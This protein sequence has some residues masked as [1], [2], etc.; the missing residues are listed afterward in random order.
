MVKLTF[1]GGVDEIGGNKILL[2]YG[3]TR[4]FLDF[5]VSFKKFKRFFDFPTVGPDNVDILIDIGDL[6]LIPNIYNQSCSKMLEKILELNLNLNLSKA[7]T[8]EI[9]KIEKE[10]VEKNNL[11]PFIDAVVITHAHAD[12]MG[13]IATLNNRVKILMGE[14]TKEICKILW[15]ISRIYRYKWKT[16]INEL[17][18]ETFKTG[19]IKEVGIDKIRIEPIAV[20][21]SVPAAYG[22]IIHLPNG[23]KIA[24]TGDFRYGGSENKFTEKFVRRLEEEKIDV[25]ICEA[26]HIDIGHWV[27]E[28][29]VNND[30]EEIIK[31]TPNLV[32]IESSTLDLDRIRTICQVAKKLGRLYALSDKH[33]YLLYKLKTCP[34]ALEQRLIVP[35]I[36]NDNNLLI[37]LDK[38]PETSDYRDEFFTNEKLKKKIIYPSDITRMQEKLIVDFDYYSVKTLQEIKP[39]PGSVYILAKTEPFDEESEISFEKL[40]NWLESFGLP[41]YHIHSSGHATPSMLL[42]FVKRVKPRILIPVHTE[43]SE[44]F[45]KFLSLYA[46]EILLPKANET[47]EI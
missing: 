10:Y 30:L 18:I 22:L 33:A 7:S 20:N 3:N 11:G 42:E 1:Y 15:E 5:G 17:N 19:D 32:L 26:T 34:A 37:F 38:K 24:Y 12:H 44:L 13:N 39:K 27:S 31:I 47:I 9:Q 25:L 2:E 40:K 41:I 8:E 43:H 36:E 14:T 23:K 45:K 6:P 46:E 28:E 4:I 29:D 16:K 21:H 35:D